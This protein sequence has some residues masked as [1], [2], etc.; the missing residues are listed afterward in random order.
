[1]PPLPLRRKPSANFALVAACRREGRRRPMIQNLCRTKILFDQKNLQA[2]IEQNLWSSRL[3]KT[4]SW[5]LAWADLHCASHRMGMGSS[6]IASAIPLLCVVGF[7]GKTS[8]FPKNSPTNPLRTYPKTPLFRIKQ[9]LSMCA[10][11]SPEVS[12]LIFH[13]FTNKPPKSFGRRLANLP[14]PDFV[15][16]ESP[17]TFRLEPVGGEI[18]SLLL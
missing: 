16:E 12:S 1:M 17:K 7:T 3:L 9:F 4:F 15:E 18:L 13:D 11:F 14:S 5:F 6:E 10:D 2:P 8:D